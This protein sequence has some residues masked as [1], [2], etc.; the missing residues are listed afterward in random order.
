MRK[1]QFIAVIVTLALAIPF[2]ALALIET[3]YLIDYARSIGGA[4]TGVIEWHSVALE[5]STHWPELAGMIIGQLLILSVLLILR[6]R[7]P[8]SG[9]DLFGNDSTPSSSERSRSEQADPSKHL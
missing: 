6:R 7:K 4:M 8:E 3:V 2:I 9:P 5:G 1:A